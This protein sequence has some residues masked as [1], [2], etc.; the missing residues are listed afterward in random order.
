VSAAEGSTSPE[1]EKHV[2]LIH[3]TL[4]PDG[5]LVAS[6][7]MPGRTMNVFSVGLM[8]ALD[9]LLDRVDG[10]AAVKSCVITSGK[11]SFLAGADLVMVRG[12][13]DAARHASHAQMFEMCGRLGRQFVRLEAS[14]KP[15]VAAVNGIAL[16][17]GLEL[18]LACRVRLVGDDPRIQLGVPEV[19]LGLLPGAG[20]TQRLPRLAGFEPALDLLLSGRAIDPASA[21]R[22]GIFSSAVPAAQLLDEAKAVARAMHGQPYDANR[23][24]RHL[25]QR[26]VPKHADATARAIAAQHGISGEAFDLYPAYSA[27]VGSVLEGARLPI[28]EAGAVEMNQFLR[29]MFSP[30]AGRMVRTLFLERQRAERELAAPPGQQLERLAV[31]AISEARGAWSQALAKVKL[32]QAAD[33]TLPADTLEL[34][35]AQGARH[36]VALRVLDD[37]P[38]AANLPQAMLAPAGPYGR[39]LEIIGADDPAAEALVALAARV[40]S[41]P[42]RTPGATSVL[43]RLRGQPLPQQAQTAVQCAAQPVAG[44]P[45]FLDVAACLAGVTPAWTGGPLTWAWAERK[46]LV[47]QFDAN[48]AAAWARLEPTLQRADE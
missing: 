32:P 9:A 44:D 20:G 41:L 39:V 29:L 34:I 36:R 45:A 2:T 17:G 37:A 40:W 48:T 14:A 11:S 46:S 18:A 23:K 12:Y 3:T 24:F 7:D 15:W 35:D 19:R 21:G 6:I 8:D 28:A 10:D 1:R 26:D 25:D 27:I 5:V 43:Q 30:V 13:C 4:E 42:W 16:G 38:A 47:S 33:D 31:G 22:L